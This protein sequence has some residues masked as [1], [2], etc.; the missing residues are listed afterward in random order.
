MSPCFCYF[1]F[2]LQVFARTVICRDLDVCARVARADGLDCITLEGHIYIFCIILFVMTLVCLFDVLLTAD[3]ITG[4]QVSKKGGMTGGFYDFRRSKLKFMNI[5][6][7]NKIS[8]DAKERELEQVRFMLQDILLI[9]AF[10][11]FEA[12]LIFSFFCLYWN[13]FSQAS[14]TIGLHA[15]GG[16]LQSFITP[17]HV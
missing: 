11:L 14:I 10:T 16:L 6:K 7:R 13:P 12:S 17:E 1:F 3:S 8:I 15:T 4:D 2:S 9:Y 5:I